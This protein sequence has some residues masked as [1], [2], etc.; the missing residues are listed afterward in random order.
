MRQLQSIKKMLTAPP[1]EEHVAFQSE[2]LEQ[3]RLSMKVVG[4]LLVM[5]SLSMMVNLELLGHRESFG[6]SGSLRYATYVFLGMTTLWLS[7][8]VVNP[9]QGRMVIAAVA[10]GSGAL[11][12]RT[13]LILMLQSTLSAVL[14]IQILAAAVAPFRPSQML[15]L[16]LALTVA[17]VAVTLWV[18]VASPEVT[19]SV[20]WMRIQL[21]SLP[22]LIM[23][24]SCT[25]M[26]G[27]LYRRRVSLAQAQ[28]E[29]AQ[30][31]EELRTVAEVSEISPV[32][33]VRCDEQ[34]SKLWANP[35]AKRYSRKV[36]KPTLNIM[37]FLPEDFERRIPEL[38]DP[39]GTQMATAYEAHGRYFNL[40]FKP[41]PGEREIIVTMHDVTAETRARQKAERYANELKEAQVKLVQS[42]KMASLGQLVAGVAHEINTPMGAICANTDSSKRALVLVRAVWDEEK[43]GERHKK[44]GKA[45]GVLEQTNSITLEA[46]RRITEIVRSLK[47]FARLDEAEKNRVDVHEGIDST[48]T[49]LQHETKGRVTI[50]KKYSTL[51]MITCFP[52]RLNQAFMNIFTNAVQAIEG[53]GTMTIETHL[54]GKT[55]VIAVTDS[56]RGIKAEH[57][58]KIFD[59]GF[60]TKGV[61]V[62]TGLG[63]SITY[64]IIEEHAGEIGVQSEEG[65]GTTVTIRLPVMGV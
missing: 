63:L 3:V 6:A 33:I 20:R 2:L 57:L 26:V 22:L 8:Q 41:S 36:G 38:I 30:L 18:P 5:L 62:G 7:R 45:L 13:E 61:G 29:R 55:A 4:V 50:E 48:L 19:N 9:G 28:V 39:G 14:M 16:G 1:E 12:A 65:K 47:S 60:T 40:A 15:A 34:G 54:E 53:Q 42:E 32:P 49:L 23:T 56:G 37:D 31:R 44:A 21:C 46:T 35:A 11:I 17:F 25:L 59:P 51:P 43:M 52:N 24:F 10:L 58:A 64:R 27:L